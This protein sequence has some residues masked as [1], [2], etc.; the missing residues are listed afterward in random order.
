MSEHDNLFSVRSQRAVLRW[1]IAMAI[2]YFVAFWVWSPL[3]L[4]TAW[5]VIQS[6]LVFKA[7]NLQE[8]AAGSAAST[9]EKIAA[10]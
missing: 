1:G 5:I 10:V 2:L 8:A 6:Y 7:L 9:P 4:F 3:T